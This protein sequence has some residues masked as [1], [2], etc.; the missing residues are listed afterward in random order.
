MMKLAALLLTPLATAFALGYYSS[1]IHPSLWVA[2]VTVLVFSCMWWGT[3]YSTV[4]LG[5]LME[6]YR[7]RVLRIR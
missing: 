7:D 2:L 3:H 5:Q 6:R 4:W 1:Q